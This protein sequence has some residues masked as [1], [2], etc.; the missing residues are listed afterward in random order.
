MMSIS[1]LIRQISIL[2]ALP[3]VVLMGIMAAAI[4]IVRDWRSALLAYALQSVILAVLLTQRL[5]MEWALLQAIVGGLVAVMLFLSARQ[6]GG[7][8]QQARGISREARWPQLPSLG[9]FRLLAVVLA[10]LVFITIRGQVH[11]PLVST[12]FRDGILWLVMAGGLGLALHEEPLHAGL[13]LLTL[14]G[15]ILMLLFSLNQSRMLLG[16]MDG[17]QLLLGLA[18][19]YLIV[20]RGLAAETNPMQLSPFRWR[21]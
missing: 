20:S 2:L 13:S 8:D 15:G 17:W 16:L 21:P 19:S 14:L 10:A 7:A 18:I 5:P 11:L 1:D 4:V 9:L 3:A 12:T 6:L